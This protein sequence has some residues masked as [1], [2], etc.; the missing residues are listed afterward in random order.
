MGK[1]SQQR[2]PIFFFEEISDTTREQT[3]KIVKCIRQKMEEMHYKFYDS[4]SDFNAGSKSTTSYE[5]SL[6]FIKNFCGPHDIQDY[7]G[8]H[9]YRYGANVVGII[10]S[11]LKQ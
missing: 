4:H 3:K 6:S 9:C 10:F 8:Q 1:S 2:F 5:S 11:P 7:R